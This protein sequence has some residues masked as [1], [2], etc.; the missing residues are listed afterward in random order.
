MLFNY[1]LIFLINF[2]FC[3]SSQVELYYNVVAIVSRRNPIHETEHT[4]EKGRFK[5]P[6]SFSD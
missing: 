2:F 1:F 5:L 3:K 4:K 6:A